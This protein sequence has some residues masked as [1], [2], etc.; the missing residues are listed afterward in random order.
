[1]NVTILHETLSIEQSIEL[2]ARLLCSSIFPKLL[3][4]SPNDPGWHARLVV[5]L[6]ALSAIS[7]VGIA[8]QIVDSSGL[9][10]SD[11]R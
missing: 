10:R 5:C 1:M 6:S 7:L 11:D 9:N 8:G 4:Y 2:E 3:P